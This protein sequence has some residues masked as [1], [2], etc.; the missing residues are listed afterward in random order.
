MAYQYKIINGVQVALTS[1]E[2]ADLEA[3][4]TEWKEWS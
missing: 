1:Q 4:D 3:R 2:I